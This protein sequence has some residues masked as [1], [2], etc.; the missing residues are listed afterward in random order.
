MM[1]QMKHANCSYDVVVAAAAVVV[2]GREERK[3]VSL[4]HLLSRSKDLDET[5]AVV[6]D[7]TAG[8]VGTAR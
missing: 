2:E 6:A 3:D 1:M 4:A 7:G 5:R 8:Q